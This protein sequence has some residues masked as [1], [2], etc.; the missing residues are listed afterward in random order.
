[1]TDILIAIQP[2]YVEQILNGNKQYEF[3]KVLPKII[4]ER[5]IIYCTAPVMA[6]V[7]V[8]DIEAIIVDTPENIWQLTNELG[9]VSSDFFFSYYKQSKKAFAYQLKNVEKYEPSKSLSD[10]GIRAAPQSFVYL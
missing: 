6:V 7:G 9:G 2:E 4:P 3:R 5:M 8:A 10:F 1:M